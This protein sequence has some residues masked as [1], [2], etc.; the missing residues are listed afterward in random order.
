MMLALAFCLA[1]GLIGVC[2]GAMLAVAVL[3]DDRW[4]SRRKL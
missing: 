1:S 3:E 2:L 4:P